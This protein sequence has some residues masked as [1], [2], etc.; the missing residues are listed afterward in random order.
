MP[1]TVLIVEDHPSF[2]EVVE[3][4]M[5]FDKGI[6]IVGN[7]RDGLAAVEKA[8]E[9]KPDVVLMDLSLPKLAGCEATK[10]ILRD[11]PET[12]IIVLSGSDQEL[13]R[14]AASAAGAHGYIVKSNFFDELGE[15]ILG[16]AEGS[17]K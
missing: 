15:A 12:K 7:V 11:R 4:V 6:S 9:V 16:L 13:D 14:R 3:M 17:A 1:V 10:Q 5:S 8:R 2:A